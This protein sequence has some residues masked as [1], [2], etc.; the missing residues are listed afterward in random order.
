MTDHAETVR[1]ALTR[2]WHDEVPAHFEDGERALAALA[3]LEREL[4]KAQREARRWEAAYGRAM[5]RIEQ[6]GGRA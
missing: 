6:A 1:K 4:A 5:R 2:A 3:A